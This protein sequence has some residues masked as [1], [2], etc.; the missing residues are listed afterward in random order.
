MM[1]VDWKGKTYCGINLDWNYGTTLKER[2][3]DCSMMG[4]IIKALQRFGILTPPVKPQDSPYQWTR[5]DYG[6]RVQLTEEPDTTLPLDPEGIKR[7]QEIIG[8]LL[9]YA[10][11]IDST[12]L[13]ALGTLASAQTKGTEATMK[14]AI[15]LLNYAATHPDA[16][17][18]FYGSSMQ[19]HIHSDASYLSEFNARSRVGGYFFLGDKDNTESTSPPPPINGAIH[20]ESIIP[21]PVMSSA[22]EA[23]TGGLFING[24][25]GAYARTVLEEMGWPQHGPTPIQTDNSV[26]EGIANESIKQRR[27]KA[28][29]MCFYWFQDHVC[30]G[31]F[32]VHWKP[33]ATNY[34]DYYTKHH[35]M[36]RVSDKFPCFP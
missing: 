13:V 6:A 32:R 15:N 35:P 20:V 21:G 4:Y 7:L 1:T 34:S 30:Q 23:E 17:V 33:R 9:F 18:R 25:E 11:A 8:V 19:L 12:M 24:K 29:D 28:M 3:V 22:S 10:R 26:A 2:W 14:A 5:P 16:I 31:Q 36:V 27:S